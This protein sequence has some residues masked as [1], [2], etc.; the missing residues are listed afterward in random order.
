MK[1]V[2]LEPGKKDEIF[3]KIEVDPILA[4]EKKLKSLRKKLREID[5]LASKSELN[6]EQAEKISRR[7]AVE[8]EIEALSH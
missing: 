2:K 8:D 5:E 6:P 4:K 1:V 7:K 3:D